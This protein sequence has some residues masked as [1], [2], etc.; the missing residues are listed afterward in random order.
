[1]RIDEINMKIIQ[2]MKNG[3]KPVSE[4]ADD[5]SITENTIR[6]RIKKM[7]DQSFLAIK[8]VV[9]TDKLPNHFLAAVGVRMKTPKLVDKAKE[10]SKLRGVVSVG[11]VTGH[12]DILLLVLLNNEF[13]LFQFFTEE[14]SKIEGVA[15]SD[16]FIMYKS[17]NWMVPY[18]L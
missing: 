12:F 4:I 10:F 16:S 8:G 18:V 3:R 17:I 7:T 11:V 14:V 5:L 13:G 2:H 9:D 15:S 1:M 6:N